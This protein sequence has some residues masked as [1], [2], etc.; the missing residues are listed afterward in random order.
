MKLSLTKPLGK[1]L[2]IEDSP[3]AIARGLAIGILLGFTPLLGL[4]TLLSLVLAA[5]LR[6]NKIAA[7]VGVTLHDLA[8]PLLPDLLWLEYDIGFWLLSRP[9]HFPPSIHHAHLQPHEWLSWTK[10]L[11]AGA[12]LLVGSLVIGC[13]ASLFTFLMARRLLAGK[14]GS[15]GR[16]TGLQPERG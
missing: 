5:G 9:H 7:I 15:P 8:L 16:E 3:D 12:P 6:G 1:L 14:R 4:K 10:F 2:K 13:P 11:S